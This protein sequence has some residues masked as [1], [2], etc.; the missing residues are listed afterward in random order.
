MSDHPSRE[1]LM[2][3]TSGK[4]APD[5]LEVLADH[6]E[7]CPT[8]EKTLTSLGDAGDTFVQRLR[9]PV[10]RAL[11]LDQKAPA[12]GWRPKYPPRQS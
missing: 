9:E 7:H 5:V 6:V 3:Y 10:Q 4:V 11:G 1:E 8:C 12:I 2:A